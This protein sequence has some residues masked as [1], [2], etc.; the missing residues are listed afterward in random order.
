MVLIQERTLPA[1]SEAEGED[2]R[3]EKLGVEE[4]RVEIARA[5]AKG[6]TG[7][8]VVLW[9]RMARMREM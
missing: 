1:I 6:L 9:E 4:V 7:F 3:V 5:G 2:S 8:A